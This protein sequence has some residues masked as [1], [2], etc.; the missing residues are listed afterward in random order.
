MD[1]FSPA[2]WI[3][4]MASVATFCVAWAAYT[5]SKKI[6]DR[7]KPSMRASALVHGGKWLGNKLVSTVELNVV[8][9][10][11]IPLYI[12]EVN[13]QD[14]FEYARAFDPAQILRLQWPIKLESGG[15]FKISAELELPVSIKSEARWDTD[16]WV[17]VDGVE[18]ENYVSW[19]VAIHTTALP[20][21]FIQPFN[22]DFRCAKA[23]P[24]YSKDMR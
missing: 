14:G 21:Q 18:V 8:N 20:T 10:G 24:R 13:W 23:Y 15:Q 17:K 1:N 19:E 4:G 12:T 9:V 5:L 2:E 7:S 22:A 16:S 11:G 6:E 3:N